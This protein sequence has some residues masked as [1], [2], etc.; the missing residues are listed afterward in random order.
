MSFY[1]QL[2]ND[3]YIRADLIDI[4]DIV[5]KDKEFNVLVELSFNDARESFVMHCDSYEKAE[6]YQRHILQQLGGLA[7]VS[8]NSV[9]SSNVAPKEAQPIGFNHV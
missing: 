6:L 5:Q 2:W 1:V 3:T 9:Q 7:P 4:I 8:L